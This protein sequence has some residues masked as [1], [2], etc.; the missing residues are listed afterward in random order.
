MQWKICIIS[1]I[2]KKLRKK[3]KERK[4]CGFVRAFS[5]HLPLEIQWCLQIYIYPSYT[6]FYFYYKDSGMLLVS[7]ALN[8]SSSRMHCNLFDV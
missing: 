5:S 4:I 2:V 3:K 1:E 7:E 8:L 6:V